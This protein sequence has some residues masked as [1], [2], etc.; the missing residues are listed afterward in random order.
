MSAS[1]ASAS[2][3]RI[4]LSARAVA[5]FAFD[6]FVGDEVFYDLR[7]RCGRAQPLVFHCVGEFLVVEELARAL[8]CREERGFR[9]PR[10]RL[11]GFLFEMRFEHFCAF[12]F[13]GERRQDFLVG[14]LLVVDVEPARRAEHLA[15]GFEDV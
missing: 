7:A 15:L 8:H 14:R 1:I 13:V 2:R 9:V 10:R 5:A 4:R 6:Q 3:K 11:C 12:L